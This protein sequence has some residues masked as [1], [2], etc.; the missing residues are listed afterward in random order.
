[1][2]GRR[3]HY[4]AV[5]KVHSQR[6]DHQRLGQVPS[7]GRVAKRSS[8][9]CVRTGASQCCDAAS[10]GHQMA[11][12]VRRFDSRLTPA[13]P[14]DQRSHSAVVDETEE[15]AQVTLCRHLHFI[16]SFIHFFAPKVLSSLGLKY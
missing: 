16:H 6:S 1:M 5:R 14:S 7:S 3:K 8:M 9:P 15:W 12:V 4:G 10:D 13:R 2:A 11:S